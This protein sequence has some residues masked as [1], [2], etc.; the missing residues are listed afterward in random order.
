MKLVIHAGLWRAALAAIPLLAAAN[1][2]AAEAAAQAKP[3]LLYSRHFNAQ[4]ETRYLPDGTYSEVLKLLGN[5]FEVRVDSEPFTDK[6]LRD[7]NVILISNPSELAVDDNPPPPHFTRTDIQ[8]IARFA[9]NG[10][11]FII[12]GN[13]EDHNLEV[14]NTNKLL[15]EFG[16][17]WVDLHTDVKLLVIPPDNPVLGGLRWAYY[18]GNQVQIAPGHPAKPRALVM[19]DLNQKLLSGDR[20]EPGALIAVAE[21]GEGRVVVVTDAGWIA[22]PALRGE[23]IGGAAIQEHDNW[24]IFRRLALWAAGR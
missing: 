21:P 12:L 19:N 1:I 18:I 2:L 13:Q 22:N 7:V 14:E 23:G 8:V 17:R 6:T 16:L 11:G 15:A 4:G 20:D 5:E 3:I 10:G 24:E 9:R